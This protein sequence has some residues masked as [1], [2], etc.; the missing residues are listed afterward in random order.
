MIGDC[1]DFA[2]PGGQNGTVPFSEIILLDALMQVP[3]R[4]HTDPAPQRG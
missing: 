3:S 4:A 1:P 2:V